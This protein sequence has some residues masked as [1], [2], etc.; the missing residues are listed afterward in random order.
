[1]IAI[2]RLTKMDS[3][4]LAELN[5]LIKQ[6]SRSA[7]SA[8]PLTKSALQRIL[9]DKNVFLF[10]CKDGKKIIGMGTLAIWHATVVGIR[11]RVEDVVVDES[12]RGRKLGERITKKL[13]QT[14]RTLGAGD[15]ELS[16]RPS[17]TAANALWLKLGFKLKETNTY[18][19]RP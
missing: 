6:L 14:A 9:K 16:S 7:H 17:R 1:M 4:T 15:I 19:F 3:R 8:R 5:G 11:S 12:Y 2:Q 10:V 18:A 13:I